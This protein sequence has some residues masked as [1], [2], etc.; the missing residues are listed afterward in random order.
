MSIIADLKSL[1]AGFDKETR[2]AITASKALTGAARD[3]QIRA[4][5]AAFHKSQ[6]VAA[7]ITLV[8]N[9]V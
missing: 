1:Q 6:G 9:A 7:A 5:V 4:S 3:D 2:D 8:E